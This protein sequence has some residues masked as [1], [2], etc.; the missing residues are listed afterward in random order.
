MLILMPY[1]SVRSMR[2]RFWTKKKVRPATVSFSI[3]LLL[4][5]P[6]SDPFALACYHAAGVK[7]QALLP[8]ALLSVY[9]NLTHEG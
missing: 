1:K 3:T 4:L 8:S 9:G 5:F 6:V 7:S 2:L